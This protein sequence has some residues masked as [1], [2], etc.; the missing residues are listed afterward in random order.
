MAIAIT[1]KEYLEH[2]HIDFDVIEHR[3]TDS[4]LETCEA[5]HIPGDR[6]AKSIL[7][8]DDDSYLMAVIPATHRL[9]LDHLNETTGRQLELAREDELVEAFADCELGAVPPTG[10]AYG[11]RTIVDAHLITQPDIYFE[12]GDHT[13]LIHVSGKQFRELVDASTAEGISRHL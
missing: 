2:Q 1:L 4:T 8:E 13:K 5:A 7:L 11:I 12:T 6:M 3:Q 10:E 9:Q